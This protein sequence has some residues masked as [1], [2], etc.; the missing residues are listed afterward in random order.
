[1]SAIVL[2]KALRALR[3]LLLR[4]VPRPMSRR[5]QGLFALFGAV[6]LVGLL[7]VNPSVGR[8]V[9]ALAVCLLLPGLGWAR[10]I[11]V[12]DLG[13]TLAWAILLSICMTSAVATTMVLSRSWSLGW[14]LAA[15]MAIAVI[16]HLPTRNLAE[17]ARTA[18]RLRP[19]N[20]L[21]GRGFGPRLTTGSPQP[22][23]DNA[24]VT[25]RRSTGR[26]RS[27]VRPS[28]LFGTDAGRP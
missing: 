15:L 28:K 13:D 6:L 17:R 3:R 20:P 18:K 23:S 2:T 24:T 22:A 1:M 25:N 14:G 5:T 10:K 19:S 27:R 11:H 8:T 7:A 12:G 21:I 4:P 9:F 26:Q 16:G